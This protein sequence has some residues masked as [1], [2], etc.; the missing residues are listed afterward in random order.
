MICVEFVD[1]PVWALHYA[2]GGFK[3]G[4][5]EGILDEFGGFKHGII[6][7]IWMKLRVLNMELLRGFG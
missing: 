3:H 4:I 2:F 7:G 1:Y 6:E 5:M